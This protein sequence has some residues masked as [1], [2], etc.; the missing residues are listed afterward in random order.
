MILHRAF[1]RILQCEWR[2]PC[3]FSHLRDFNAAKSPR[4]DTE[5]NTTSFCWAIR[6][7]WGC[8]LREP[9]CVNT[10]SVCLSPN[11]RIIRRLYW[12]TIHNANGYPQLLVV[13]DVPARRASNMTKG[14]ELCSRPFVVS[15]L[16]RAVLRGQHLLGPRRRR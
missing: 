15:M 13:P 4:V 1:T 14:R 5:S 12:K 10:S 7:T 2:F 8:H 9:P 11:E 3:N 16:R 6:H